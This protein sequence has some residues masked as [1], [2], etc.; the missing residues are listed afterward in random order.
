[1]LDTLELRRGDVPKRS[2]GEA[3]KASIQWFDSTRRLQHRAPVPM[4]GIRYQHGLLRIPP[5]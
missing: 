4:L 3:C 2:K 1:M 5:D